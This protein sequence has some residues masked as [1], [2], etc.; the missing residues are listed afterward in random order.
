MTP[1]SKVYLV[2]KLSGMIRSKVVTPVKYKDTL[3]AAGRVLKEMIDDGVVL[4][5]DCGVVL[6]QAT[7]AT[8]HA[9]R[10]TE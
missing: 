8:T 3:R 4:D 10:V 6:D 2:N 5:T 7:E 1:T 9:Y